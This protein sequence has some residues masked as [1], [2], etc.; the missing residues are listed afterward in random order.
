MLKS[1]LHRKAQRG[2]SNY[3]A[4]LY[5]TRLQARFK[6]WRQTVVDMKHREH[7]M[8]KFV[9]HWRNFRFY[10][11]KASFKNWI[12]KVRSHETKV[13][14]RQTKI[15]GDEQHHVNTFKAQ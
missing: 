10:F 15:A 7:L 1:D 4:R 2:M 11:M 5:Y 13:E 14:I 8:G 3:F 9:E 12:H 6:K